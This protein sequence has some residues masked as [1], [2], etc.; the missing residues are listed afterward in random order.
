MSYVLLKSEDMSQDAQEAGASGAAGSGSGDENNAASGAESEALTTLNSFW[1]IINEEVKRIK[2]VDAKNQNL[3]LARIKKIMKLDEDVKMISAEAP[4]LFAKASEIFIHELTLRAWVYTEDNKRRTLQRSDIAMAISRY[5]QFDFLIDIVPREEIKLIKKD[6][7]FKTTSNCDQ[8]NQIQYYFQL[9]QQHQ[10]ALQGQAPAPAQIQVQTSTPVTLGGMPNNII[11]TSPTAAPQGAQAPAT[12]AMIVNN[13][14]QQNQPLQVL[15]QIV[16]PTGEIQ[17]IQI[18]L[19]PS[20]LN[21]IRMQSGAQQQPIIIQTA[22]PQQQ[23]GQPQI[24]Q[25][26]QPVSQPQVSASPMFINASA[27]TATAGSSTEG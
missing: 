26:G 12:N 2:T 5:D 19:S 11:V 4:L 7:E 10:Q 8:G 15:Q 17:H 6:S 14:P 20:Q 22:S 1:P 18:P 3:P 16:T 25:L 23:A 21:L 9:A 13:V 24:L 27:T